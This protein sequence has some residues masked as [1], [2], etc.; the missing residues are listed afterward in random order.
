[1]C[2]PVYRRSTSVAVWPLGEPMTAF[3]SN[4]VI[5]DIAEAELESVTGNGV[6][7]T[8]IKYQ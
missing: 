1:M 8:K 5:E 2:F 7:L 6:E 4:Y 3:V